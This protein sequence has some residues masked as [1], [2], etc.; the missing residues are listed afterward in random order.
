MWKMQV[1]WGKNFLGRVGIVN[2][3][4]KEF[5]LRPKRVKAQR[6]EAAKILFES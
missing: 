2:N 5:G 3:V 4:V 1:F 6:R